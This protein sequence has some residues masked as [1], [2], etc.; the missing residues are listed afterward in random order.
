MSIRSMILASLFAALLAISSQIYIPIGPVPH[1]L[2]IMFV[3]L[4]GFILGGR[5]GFISVLLWVLLGVFGLP[6]FSEG[7]SGLA[8][9]AGPTGGFLVGFMVAAYLVGRCV[10][11]GKLSAKMTVAV[12]LCVLF[13]VYG[14]GLAGFLLSFHFFLH[15]SMTLNQAMLIAVIPFLPFDI[16]K[17]ALAAYLGIKIRRALVRAGFIK[18]RKE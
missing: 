5:W 8:A 16:I 15:K 14:L 18:G 12:L 17:T 10:E 7:K 3:F 9:L 6:V 11:Q 4:A 13:I 2:Q 1:T